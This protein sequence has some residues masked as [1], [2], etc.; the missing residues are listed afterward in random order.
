MTSRGNGRADSSISV[1]PCGDD[2]D[3]RGVYAD[4]SLERI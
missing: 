1:D 2:G 3:G 4:P